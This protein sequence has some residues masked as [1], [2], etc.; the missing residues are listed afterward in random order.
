M[1]EGD[2]VELKTPFLSWYTKNWKLE[3]MCPQ[4][5]VL[6]TVELRDLKDPRGDLIQVCKV[7]GWK[8]EIRE[9]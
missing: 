3:S 2:P 8:Q 5:D 7:C 9:I 1:Q 6:M 4:C